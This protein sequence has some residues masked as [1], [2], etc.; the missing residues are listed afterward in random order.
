MRR[1]TLLAGI[2]L[3]VLHASLALAREEDRELVINISDNG[4]PPFAIR[5]DDDS[6]S[7]IMWDVLHYIALTHGYQLIA[8]EI[9]P[10]RVED[11]ILTGELDGTMR[12]MEW[13][14]NADAFIFTNPIVF[15]QDVIYTRRDAPAIEDLAQLSGTRLLTR[16][17]FHYPELDPLIEEGHIRRFDVTG[18]QEQFNRLRVA[19]RFDALIINNYVAEW[20][21]R[22]QP[23]REELV[24]QPVELKMTG[25]RFMFAPRHAEFVETFNTALREITEQGILERILDKYR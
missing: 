1:L 18:N 3:L 17:G 8:R 19:D 16:L 21:L 24:L 2:A 6:V 12:A 11:F 9:P 14:H 4:Y 22:H 20:E 15:V 5:H 25:Y 7:G 23:W 10:N 13:T